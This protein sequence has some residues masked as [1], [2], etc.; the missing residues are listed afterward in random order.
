MSVPRAKKKKQ[1]TNVPKP[2]EQRRIMQANMMCVAVAIEHLYEDYGWR[3]MRINR[4][5]NTFWDEL[6]EAK[7]LQNEA[8]V[9]RVPQHIA[10][11]AEKATGAVIISECKGMDK[12]RADCYMLCVGCLVLALR[13]LK[14]NKLR[15]QII[16]KDI[17]YHLET[18][19]PWS[20]YKAVYEMT[21]YDVR[22]NIRWD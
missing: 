17:F 18:Y 20:V 6:C 9:K 7:R 4:L 19:E 14:V 21:G 16:A 12:Y 8:Y 2:P 1:R 5:V 13:K 15:C 3:T 22:T 10:T 11:Q